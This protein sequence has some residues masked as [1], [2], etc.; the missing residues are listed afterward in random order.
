[1]KRVAVNYPGDS[2]GEFLARERRSYD[3][4]QGPAR[5]E[6]NRCGNRFEAAPASRTPTA[7]AAVLA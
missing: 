4:L 5:K 6:S 7:E 3:A 1:M 2:T